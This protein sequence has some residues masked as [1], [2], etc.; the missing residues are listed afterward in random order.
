MDNKNKIG[1]FMQQKKINEMTISELYQL[2]GIVSKRMQTDGMILQ[3]VDV[4]IDELNTSAVGKEE[5]E[6]EDVNGNNK[7]V[8]RSTEAGKSSG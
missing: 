2:R 6:K 5:K 8:Q 4:R 7:S 1:G 3:S